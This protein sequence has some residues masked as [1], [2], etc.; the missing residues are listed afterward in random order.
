VLTQEFSDGGQS[1]D[2]FRVAL[3]TLDS[4]FDHLPATVEVSFIKT[5]VQGA[6]LDVL[7]GAK[8][9]LRRVNMVV[10]ECQDLPD[11]RDERGCFFAPELH[12]TQNMAYAHVLLKQ[13]TTAMAA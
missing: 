13:C 12:T 11:G 8:N 1:A 7:R 5:D 9:L 10:A 3:V 4:I 6:D 2:Q